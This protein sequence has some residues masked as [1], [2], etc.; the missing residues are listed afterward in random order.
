MDSTSTATATA[1]NRTGTISV[2]T[3]DEGLLVDLRID[4]RELRYG[5]ARLADEILALNRRAALEAAALRR[6]MLAAQG[7]PGDVLDRIGLPTHADVTR[8]QQQDEEQ[9]PASWLRPV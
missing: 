9:P 5:A 6:D 2:R 8:A 4:P 3:T 7:V 1:R